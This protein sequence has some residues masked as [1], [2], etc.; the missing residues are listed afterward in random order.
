MSE[1]DENGGADWGMCTWKQSCHSLWP[2]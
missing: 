2:G 1:V